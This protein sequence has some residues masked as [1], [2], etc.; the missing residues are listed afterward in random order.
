MLTARRATLAAVV[1]LAAIALS[2]PL[3]AG[4]PRPS[5][6]RIAS[7]APSAS[8]SP[9]ASPSPSAESAR[10][11]AAVR[12]LDHAKTPHAMADVLE[13]ARLPGA[14]APAM[15]LDAVLPTA[16]RWLADNKLQHTP[17]AQMLRTLVV[18]LAARAG[19]DDVLQRHAQSR[20][21]VR[22]WSW[23]G[24]FGDEHGS[25]FTRTGEVERHAAGPVDLALAVSGRNGLVRWQSL[26]DGFVRAGLRAPLEILLDRA[27]DAIIYAQAWV[28]PARPG[29][30]VLRLG[31]DGA[32][33]VWLGGVPVLQLEAKPELFGIEDGYL[34]LPEVDTAPVVLHAG[35][36]RLLV[37][38][39]PTGPSLPL[40]A[41][42]ADAQGEPIDLEVSALPPPDQASATSHDITI[43]LAAFPTPEVAPDLAASL[44]W[45]G[46]DKPMARSPLPALMA[47]AWHGWPMPPALA[48]RLLSALPDELPQQPQV[49]LGHAMLAGEAGDRIDRL[50]QWAAL[51]PDSVEVLIAE[52]QAL[53]RMGKS[54]AAHRRWQD[55]AERT[56][57]HPEL[58]SIRAC[59]VRAE[60]WTRL[61]AE[62]AAG[63]LLRRCGARW[64]DSPEML[65]A[66]ARAA[67]AHDRLAEAEPLQAALLRLE[68]GALERHMAHL[69]A[70]VN[71]GDAEAALGEA[72]EISKRFPAHSRA[73]E[74][75]AHLLL[76]EGR[77]REAELALARVPA[78]L[79]RAATQ[80]LRA[81]IATALGH[82]EEA[83][84]VLRAA[85]EQSPARAD[86]RTRLQ[87]LR[88]NGDF[89]AWHRRDLLALV[90][91]DLKTPRS[92]P[93]E[94]R[95]RQTVL[96]VVGNGQQARYDAEVYYIGPGGEPAHNVTIEYAPGVS[97]AE[98][99]QAAVV[100]ADGRVER[101]ASQDVEQLG[102]DESGM[103]FDLERITLGFKNLKL[104]DSL[105][106]EYVVRDLQP[107]PFA[108]VF[109][110]LLTLGETYPVRES[111]VVV[112]LPQG[113]PF[114]HEVSTPNAAA[115]K[116][117]MT[118]RSLPVAGTDRDDA[119]PWDEWRLQMGPIAAAE[120]EERMP[121]TTDVV[122]YLHMS[123]FASWE[124]AARWYAGLMAEALP[125]RGSDLA[126]RDTALRLTQGLTTP[127]QKARALYNY[128]AAQVRYVGLEFGI[129]SLKPH[130]AREVMQRQF[131]DCKDKATLL[132]A[133]LG[134]V[135]ID[136]QVALV[137]TQDEGRLHDS[138]ASLGVFNHAIA[139]VPEL[140]WW[141]DATAQHH[142]PTE[143]PDGDAGGMALRIPRTLAAQARLERLPDAPAEQHARDEVLDLAVQPDGAALLT[144]TLRL[145]GLPAAQVRA[146]LD[147][148]QTRK[149]RLEHD[150][151]PR[152]PGLTVTEV[153][154]QGIEP[155]GD[156][157]EVRVQGRVPQWAQAR[158]TTLVVAALR[159]PVAYGL[160]LAAALVRKQEV[161]LDHG[162]LETVTMRVRPPPGFTVVRL[163]ASQAADGPGGGAFTLQAKTLTDGAAELLVRMHLSDRRVAAKDYAGFRTWLAAVDATLRG[164]LV[165]QPTSLGVRQ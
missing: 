23:L 120:T 152:F 64:P 66:R 154:V 130:P 25:A 100:R 111:D 33:R 73:F 92:Q 141:L 161:V 145:R 84:A 125:A 165:L 88:P 65:E 97:R 35:W 59:I 117:A 135:G 10:L 44:R 16:Q 85:V 48:E 144:L 68:P 134:E 138:V 150:L 163:P 17:A 69:Q 91:K 54:A 139:Y 78:H 94:Q 102:D 98:V 136:A 80:E 137:R 2:R 27:D 131:G 37:K 101:N 148:A 106:V 67:M 31:V 108:L 143:L 128:A 116:I 50:R 56:G 46:D 160:A 132:V 14:L 49:A 13:I 159:P 157:V 156:I 12:R 83:L 11:S 30:A 146:R 63:E 45:S 95:L 15:V 28:K 89:F 155:P 151:A 57:R 53:D 82:R 77:P 103:Y 61:D 158:G 19:R 149:E 21:A 7:Q 41:S 90:K 3:V 93:L 52:V 42:F 162:F 164:E 104:G 72:A 51:L 8:Q 74:V 127:A 39:A 71:L 109:G 99:L 121:G 38:L 20:G 126:L 18:Q 36:Q 58:E 113:T 22:H 26:P 34:M 62:L 114:H 115:A 47:L 1:I 105:V 133:L 79:R 6:P 9:S 129:H 5:P 87:M 119:G 24:P 142:A 75:A 70:R 43:D 123:S 86:L 140:N 32:A 107:T 96:Q 55:F 153:T 29:P 4:A 81:R 40:S 147:T 110:E 122:P 76:A 124:A 118:H 60:L 112:L